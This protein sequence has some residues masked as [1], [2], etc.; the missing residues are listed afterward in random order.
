MSER[1][2]CGDHVLHKPTGEKWVVAYSEGN[3]L[4]PIGWPECIASLSDCEITKKCSDE[5]HRLWVGEFAKSTRDSFRTRRVLALY[6]Q[7]VA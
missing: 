3:D 4:S 6:G 2:R 1:P 7:A 5:E